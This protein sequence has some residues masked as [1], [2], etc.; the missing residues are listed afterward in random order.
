MDR[1]RQHESHTGLS[2]VGSVIGL[3]EHRK[4]MLVSYEDID[5]SLSRGACG[6]LPSLR[7]F[8]IKHVDLVEAGIT[9]DEGRTMW[10]EA[11]PSPE[12]AYGPL[13]VPQIDY[14]LDLSVS[15]PHSKESGIGTVRIEVHV[16]SVFRPSQV[17]EI[18]FGQFRPS[19][20]LEIEQQKCS[21][22]CGESRDV[23]AIRTPT[24]RKEAIGTRQYR[25]P[26][27]R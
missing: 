24:R 10:S 2:T 1:V 8:P 7:C 5:T 21:R 14:S 23:T 20:G 17:T 4:R 11:G 26:A 13:D 15:N 3:R 12:S 16:F 18:C 19:L 6:Q 27:R 9:L 25:E 22:V